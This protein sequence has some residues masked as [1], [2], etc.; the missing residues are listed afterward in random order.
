MDSQIEV[1]NV[2]ISAMTITKLNEDCL[3]HIFK[4][5]NIDD[6]VSV[7]DSSKQFER[8]IDW[9]FRS[10]YKNSL[11]NILM[12]SG[13][14]NK[15]YGNEN[16]YIYDATKCLKIL[17]YFGHNISKLAINYIKTDGI[18][19]AIIDWYIIKYCNALT[20]IRIENAKTSRFDKFEQTFATVKKVSFR[21]CYLSSK[22]ADFN[23][24]FSQMECLQ[25]SGYL[26]FDDCKCFEQYFPNLEAIF[27]GGQKNNIPKSHILELFRL[28]PQLRKLDIHDYWGAKFLHMASNYLDGLEK[29]TISYWMIDDF[30]LDSTAIQMKNVKCLTIDLYHAREIIKMPLLLDQLETLTVS[31][32]CCTMVTCQLNDIFIDF[33]RQHS[34]LRKLKIVWRTYFTREMDKIVGCNR[35]QKRKL[36]RAASNLEEIYLINCIF[37]LHEAI[38]FLEEC[39]SLRKFSLTLANET[40]YDALQMHLG[41]YWRKNIDGFKHVKFER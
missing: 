9:T 37:S 32:I 23:K 11:I 5:L 14:R 8:S 20:D 1:S 18:W 16:V 31:A 15:S 29:L 12:I 13:S 41:Q 6:L 4:Y 34:K 21:D 7:A 24:R 38:C 33:V 39:K 30:A 22:L 36:A 10:K 35:I 40:D 3:S 25:L 19:G 26:R 2:P 27:I 17:R 28:N